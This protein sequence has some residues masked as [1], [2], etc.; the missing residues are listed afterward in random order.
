MRWVDLPVNDAKHRRL[1]RRSLSE[2]GR[3]RGPK[4]RVLD[5]QVGRRDNQGVHERLSALAT[6]GHRTE[7]GQLL[8]IRPGR[9]SLT[10]VLEEWRELPIARGQLE[11]SVA[12]IDRV[13][14]FPKMV[15]R[16]EKNSNTAL[17]L[18]ANVVLVMHF[19]RGIDER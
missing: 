11:R 1:V 10:V 4:A 12:P 5:R 14:P 7:N 13:E 8:S 15:G 16:A 17:D 2:G 18:D 6:P 3:R 9:A 19:S